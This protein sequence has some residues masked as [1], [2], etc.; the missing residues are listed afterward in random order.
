MNRILFYENLLKH[1]EKYTNICVS[2]WLS[3]EILQLSGPTRSNQSLNFDRHKSTDSAN[4][5]WWRISNSARVIKWQLEWLINIL[6]SIT[7]I[8]ILFNLVR[9]VTFIFNFLPVSISFLPFSLSSFLYLS[10][11]LSFFTLCTFP[12][13][14]FHSFFSRSLCRSLMISP[15]L[16]SWLLFK[17]LL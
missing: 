1:L 12:S 4:G 9:C 8:P 11:S 17:F 6:L 3:K 7:I 5:G 10:L 2:Q 13:V 16:F 15:F 14:S